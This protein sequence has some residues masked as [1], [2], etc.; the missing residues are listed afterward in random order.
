MKRLTLDRITEV[1]PRLDELRPVLD[2]LITQSVPDAERE[3]TG[4][5]ELGTLGGRLVSGED[6]IAAVGEIA[7]AERERMANLYAAAAEAIRCL[8]EGDGGGAARALLRA[9][10]LEE[11]ADRPDRVEAWAAA[12]FRATHEERDRRPASLAL[13]RWAWAESAQGKLAEALDRYEEAHEIA[14]DSLDFQGA[15]EA[16][17]GAGNVLEQQ[18]SWDDAETWYRRALEVM[19]ADEGSRPEVWHAQLNIHIVLRSAGSLD[20]SLV[21]LQEAS[22]SAEQNGDESALPFLENARGQLHMAS[23]AFAEAEAHFR[24]GLSSAANAGA[25]VTIRLNLA[26]ALLAQDRTLDAKEE[27]REA[28]REALSSGVVPKLPEVYRILG[29]IVSAEHN[30]DAFVFFERALDIVRERRLPALEEA[31]TLQAYAESEARRGEEDTA[32]ELRERMTECYQAL[33][34]SNTRQTWAD[35]YGP[36]PEPTESERSQPSVKPSGET[37]A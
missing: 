17:I 33:G 10:A 13:R 25:R 14:R 21:W 22:D 35:S 37:D 30:P 28:E 34:M 27:A 7:D 1:L 26:E 19:E 5:G 29:R 6:L 15:A 16:A 2:H 12:A 11:R 18:G 36:G 4:G 23:G 8:G 9:A 3:W 31:L 32:R 24:A 20:E